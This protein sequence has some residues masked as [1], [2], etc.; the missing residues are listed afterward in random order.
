MHNSPRNVIVGQYYD[1]PCMQ[2]PAGVFVPVIGP[3]HCD[4][5]E[6]CSEP[7][8]AHYHYDYRFSEYQGFMNGLIDNGVPLVYRRMQCVRTESDNGR[9]LWGMIRLAR[10]YH[11]H[12]LDI[13]NPVCPHQNIPI[14]NK[15]GQCS[16]HGLC[17][18]LKTGRMKYVL[19]FYVRFKGQNKTKIL[20][21]DREIMVLY[22]NTKKTFIDP[23]VEAIDAKGRIIGEHQ[24]TNMHVAPTDRLKISTGCTNR[25]V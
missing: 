14:V 25:K 18:N 24:F 12:T 5:P 3:P 4:G 20:V 10:V 15:N 17:W 16:G 19:P 13:H 23:F 21:T 9:A 6:I 11:N 2:D 1:V 22:N 7:T 8:V